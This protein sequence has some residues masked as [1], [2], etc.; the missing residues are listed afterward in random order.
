MIY[1][2]AQRITDA[3]AAKHFPISVV[4][5]P[6]QAPAGVTDQRIVIERDRDGGDTFSPSTGAHHNP[7]RLAVRSVGVRAT[8]WI[9]SSLDGARVQDH[10]A[11]CDAYVDALYCAVDRC[12]TANAGARLFAPSE[13]RFLRASETAMVY[14]ETWPGVAYLMRWRAPRGVFDVTFSGAGLPTARAS[15]T[16]TE[17]RVSRDGTDVELVET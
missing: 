2:L 12:M 9:K 7:R 10:E 16:T 5:G 13:A 4:Y 3:L 1:E 17:V 14:G 8:L 15:A 6:E 11:A